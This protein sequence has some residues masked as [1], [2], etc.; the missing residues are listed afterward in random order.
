MRSTSAIGDM[1]Y[2]TDKRE[3]CRIDLCLTLCRVPSPSEFQEHT[4]RDAYPDCDKVHSDALMYAGYSS[5]ALMYAGYS[6]DA[7]MYAG[8]SSDALMYAGHSSDALM[9]AGYSSD[10][11]FF[12]KRR[13][14]CKTTV[15]S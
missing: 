5:D 11:D 1:I 7:L 9:Y 13:I 3:V 12:K 4:L 6:S 14:S 2:S 10:A 15:R 8:Y